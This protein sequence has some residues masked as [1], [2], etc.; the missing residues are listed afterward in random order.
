MTRSEYED[1]EGY[2]VAAVVG[3]LAAKDGRRSEEISAH[4][5]SVAKAFQAE[6]LKQL[7]E[8]PGYES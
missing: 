7:G 2:A 5:F 1:I 3:L 8:K 4:A 6:K